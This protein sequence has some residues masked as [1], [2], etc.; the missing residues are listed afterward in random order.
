MRG[1]TKEKERE[2]WVAGDGD[3]EGDAGGKERKR[4][5]EKWTSHKQSGRQEE[6]GGGRAERP[7]EMRENKDKGRER[8]KGERETTRH[9][10]DQIYITVKTKE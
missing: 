7:E 2:G 3:E 9:R 6:R 5:K 8:I 4:L 1:V 10:C